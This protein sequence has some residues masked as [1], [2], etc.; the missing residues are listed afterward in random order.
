M[1]E[2]VADPVVIKVQNNERPLDENRT[3]DKPRAL[4]SGPNREH[5]FANMLLKVDENA[6]MDF[7]QPM[8]RCWAY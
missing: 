7:I 8:S 4:S 5:I 6:S 2:T 3:S 1:M